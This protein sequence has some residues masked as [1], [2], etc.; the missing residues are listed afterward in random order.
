[1]SSQSNRHH[2]GRLVSTPQDDSDNIATR[3]VLPESELLM[4]HDRH[5]PLPS[6][7]DSNVGSPSYF[8]PLSLPSPTPSSDPTIPHSALSNHTQYSPIELIPLDRFPHTPE[9]AHP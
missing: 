5:G 2:Y 4:A 8:N 9:N 7:H 3:G 6:Q 1:M